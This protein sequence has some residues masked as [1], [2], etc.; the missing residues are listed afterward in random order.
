MKLKIS[1]T[2]I[3]KPMKKIKR[4]R[5]K[6]NKYVTNWDKIIKL[7]TNNFFIK[8]LITNIRNQNNKNRSWNSY[9]KKGL[10]NI[11]QRRRETKN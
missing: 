7:K 3:K 9:K 10:D 8:G 2:Y 5:T 11:F 6:K 1:K 4:I